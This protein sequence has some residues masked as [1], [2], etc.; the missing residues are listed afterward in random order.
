MVC[1]CVIASVAVVVEFFDI[2]FQIP[3]LI[4]HALGFLF[5]LFEIIFFKSSI[6]T[7]ITESHFSSIVKIRIFSYF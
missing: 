2:F 5:K 3:H 6:A 1:Y 4:L 7:N